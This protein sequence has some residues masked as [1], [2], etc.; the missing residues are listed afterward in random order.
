MVIPVHL[1][2]YFRDLAGTAQLVIEL[3][4]GGSIADLLDAVYQQHPRLGAL[5]N[6]TLIAVGVDY[7]GPS[8]V[9]QPG[10]DVSLFPP[11]QGG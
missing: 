6:S 1:W 4:P 3:P 7:Q 11:V 5:R 9:L 2:S 8:Y 10:D